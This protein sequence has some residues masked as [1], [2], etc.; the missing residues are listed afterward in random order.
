MRACCSIVFAVVAA[1]TALP[2]LADPSVIDRV[3]DGE[4]RVCLT[5]DYRPFSFLRPDGRFEGIDVDLAQSLAAALK[6]R[7]RFVRTTWSTLLDDFTAGR[8]DIGMGGISITLDRQARAAFSAMTMVDGKVPI[9]RCAD[10]AQYGSLAAIDRPGVR[11]VVNP[12]G[13]NERF[14]RANLKQADVR[15][16]A[17]NVTIFDEIVAGRADVMI[18]D[19]S[20]TLLQHKLRPS[21]C[22]VPLERPLQYSEKAYLLPRDDVAFKAFVDQW[23]HLAKA[24]G[25]YDAVTDRW[26]K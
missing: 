20:E 8:C 16:H 25:E 17:D 4:L 10:V 7:P 24:T 15:V 9:V 3:R 26:L 1:A 21:L 23:L 18:T 22:P 6:A 12:G 14:A 19:A 5:G 2:A 13:T 11:A